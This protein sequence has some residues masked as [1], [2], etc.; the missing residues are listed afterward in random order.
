MPDEKVALRPIVSDILREKGKYRHVFTLICYK[1][2][3]EQVVELIQA[4][5]GKYS[6]KKSLN[7]AGVKNI[8]HNSEL[9]DMFDA[10]HTD[11]TNETGRRFYDQVFL[12]ADLKQGIDKFEITHLDVKTLTERPGQYAEWIASKELQ[13]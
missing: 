5:Q 9:A 10:M 13:G 6:G 1:Q 2:G 8:Y 4:W 7:D 12:E 11:M 3:D